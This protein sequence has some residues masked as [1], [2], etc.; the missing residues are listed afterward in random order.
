MMWT[1][2]LWHWSSPIWWVVG[3]ILV[4]YFLAGR[5]VQP[6][7]LIPLLLG[8]LFLSMAYVSPIGYLADGFVFSA[9]MIQH[10]VMLLVVPLCLLLSLPRRTSGGSGNSD[11]K[12]PAL[13]II[14]TI[15]WIGGVGAMWFWHVPSL[16]TLSTETFAV[17]L[18]RDASFLLAGLIFWWPIYGPLERMRLDPP[19]GVLYLFTACL[20]CSLLGIYITFTSTVV[21]P[22][23]ATPADSL[24][25]LVQLQAA[26]LTPGVDQ[27]I[28]GLLMWIPPCMLYTGAIISL[29]AR[30][31]TS[32]DHDHSTT[33]IAPLT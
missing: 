14:A 22:V 25:I 8:L 7:R 19:V 33:T 4:V 10:L 16:C 2:E 5:P 24:G 30:W 12:A 27:N 9:H 15:G 6:S 23:F 31:Y 21:C 1:P 20:G 28:G 17:G 11:D 26:G 32:V 29:L 13:K 18:L 3:L